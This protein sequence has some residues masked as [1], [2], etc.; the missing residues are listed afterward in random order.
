[1]ID[2]PDKPDMKWAIYGPFGPKKGSQRAQRE[3]HVAENSVPNHAINAPN[4]TSYGVEGA[5]PAKGKSR[6]DKKGT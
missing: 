6:K 3:H 1:M 4:A 5:K 2:K